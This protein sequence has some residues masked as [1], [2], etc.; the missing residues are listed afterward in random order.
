[1][2]KYTFS[3]VITETSDGR[4]TSKSGGR[5]LQ[6][7]RKLERQGLVKVNQLSRELVGMTERS[8]T[9]RFVYQVTELV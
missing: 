5:T 3:H 7:A 6:L 4:R 1:M 8:G 9:S 2:K